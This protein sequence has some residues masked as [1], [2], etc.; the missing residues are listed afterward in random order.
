MRAWPFLI[1]LAGMLLAT[2]CMHKPAPNL[3][4]TWQG[5]PI[6]VASLEDK[7]ADKM[8]ILIM[9]DKSMCAHTALRISSPQHGVIFWDPAGGYGKPEYPVV[10]KRKDDLVIEPVPTIPDYLE[11]RQYLPTAKVEIF[12]YDLT[13]EQSRRFIELLTPKPGEKRALFKTETRPL[14]CSTAVSSFL[15]EHA[16]DILRVEKNFFPHAF[17]A[18]LY[19]SKPTRIVLWDFDSKEVMQ[20]HVP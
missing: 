1:L 20:Y 16:A 18:Q 15:K 13:P 9:Y 7:P 14:Y 6:Q 17:S 3:P 5:T 2:G 4:A 10:A 12:E 8:Y 19:Q 11:F